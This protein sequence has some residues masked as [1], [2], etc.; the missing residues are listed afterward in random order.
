MIN[1]RFLHGTSRVPNA[2]V[3]WH[4]FVN[5]LLSHLN[6]LFPRE[7]VVG[8]TGQIE[9]TLLPTRE[10]NETKLQ[11]AGI[12]LL[13]NVYVIPTATKHTIDANISRY[14]VS[15][16]FAVHVHTPNNSLTSAHKQTH[17]ALQIVAPSR[18]RVLV[19][20]DN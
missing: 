6:N 10:K 1:P 20:G 5:N 3:E 12:H 4:S 19:N 17:G 2:L 9:V 7:L 11:K 8:G 18:Q 14:H 15:V 16:R 13:I